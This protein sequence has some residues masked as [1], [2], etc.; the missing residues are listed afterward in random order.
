MSVLRQGNLAQDGSLPQV[1]LV[2]EQG[3]GV[4]EEIALIF[5]RRSPKVGFGVAFQ[6]VTSWGR[7][8]S[9]GV[10]LGSGWCNPFRVDKVVSVIFPRVARASQPWAV[11]L[12]PFGIGEP[13]SK[14]PSTGAGLG[15]SIPSVESA[16]ALAQSTTLRA[17]RQEAGE[18]FRGRFRWEFQPYLPLSEGSSVPP[19]SLGFIH[20][21]RDCASWL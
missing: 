10:A 14:A 4:G 15:Y 16:R 19:P 8:W 9:E 11:L 2:Q 21:P 17:I 3:L 20:L 6:A 18:N 5:A 13:Q 1:R 12:N 7:F